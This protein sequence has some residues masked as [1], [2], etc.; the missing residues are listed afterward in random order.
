MLK[1]KYI[2]CSRYT[3]ETQKTTLRKT[4]NGGAICETIVGCACQKLYPWLNRI[5]KI[6]VR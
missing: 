5:S 6:V 1:R 2:S 4:P 3:G